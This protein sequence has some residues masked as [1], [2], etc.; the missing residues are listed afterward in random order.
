MKNK[1]IVFLIS[2][3]L[4]LLNCSVAFATS[5]PGYASISG[6][7]SDKIMETPLQGVYVLIKCGSFKSSVITDASGYYEFPQVPIDK[8]KNKDQD[9]AQI[10]V[11]AKQYRP[12][13][14]KLNLKPNKNY[15]VDFAL[16]T[17][18]QYP[19]L[20]GKIIDSST[21]E[22]IAGALITVKNPKET[23]TAITNT[24][25]HYVLRIMNR[26]KGKYTVEASADGYISSA[27]QVLT[28]RP[29]LT[30][31]L[32]FSLDKVMLGINV[33]PDSWNIGEIAPG[34]IA[35]MSSGQEIVVS[36]IGWETNQTYSLMVVNPSGWTVSQTSVGSDKYILNA[37]FAENPL[38][39]NWNEANHALS[40]EAQK[41][42]N[43]KFAADQTGV[44]VAPNEER[45]LWLQ[46]KAPTSTTITQQQEIE[47]IINTQAP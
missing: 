31:T 7:V 32:N 46:F 9:K 12:E 38:T 42:T 17:L 15:T 8:K 26:R 44:N 19:I 41:A 3:C 45:T 5:S 22:G 36:N 35:T 23:Y 18:F 16:N 37:S 29:R 20:K 28:T 24:L 1:K 6:H 25:G 30:Y 21:S 2:F 11:L 40:T 13:I 43:T 27:P 47:V 34:N 14:K 10:I 4:L 39:I 33:S